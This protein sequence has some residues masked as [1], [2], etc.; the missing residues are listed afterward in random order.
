MTMAGAKPMSLVSVINEWAPD[1]TTPQRAAVTDPLSQRGGTWGL[2]LDY[3]LAQVAAGVVAPPG[4]VATAATP[5][6]R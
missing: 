3:I 1:F 5:G 6:L 2:L 4:S